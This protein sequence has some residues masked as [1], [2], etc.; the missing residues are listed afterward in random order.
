MLIFFVFRI[1]LGYN[2]N[3]IVMKNKRIIILIVSLLLMIIPF[4]LNI[5]TIFKLISLIIGIILF[6]VYFIIGK[7]MNLF[8]IIYLPIL[9]LV[10]TYSLDYMKTYILDVSPIYILEN[11][12]NNKVSIYN[13]L[14]YRI[15]KCEDK[16]IF[17]N[18]YKMNF[19]CDTK[20]IDNL[21]INTLLAVPNTTYKK[22]KHDFIKVTGKISKIVGK[23]KLE[24]QSY[25]QESKDIN[26]YVK[27]NEGSKLIIYLNEEELQS[28]KIYDYITVVG[29]LDNFNKK[30]EELTLINPK[31][32]KNDL[33][34]NFTLEVIESKNCEHDLKEYTDKFYTL[35]LDNVY[36]NYEVD[37]YELAY[38]LKD[39]KI[40]MADLIKDASVK[41]EN[42]Y[43]LYELEKF[44]IL[45]CQND[46]N[47]LMNKDL[48][49]D[50]SLCEE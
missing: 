7:K 12:I 39:G 5:F 4:F 47:I 9:L 48:E 17:D 18:E 19:A 24:M 15:Y 33:Y 36:V 11:K 30:D 25:I 22:Y 29:L 44:N 35:C 37:K 28:Y 26:G 31:V 3:V 23:S 21:D 34:N 42:N 40:T 10:F 6:D 38:V 2:I 50:Y 16:Y 20:A 27:F 13:S 14:F 32:E 1:V 43:H 45:S 49:G 8:W 46:K 41:N